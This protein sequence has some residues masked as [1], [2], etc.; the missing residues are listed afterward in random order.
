MKGE[1]GIAVHALVFLNHKGARQSS[2]TIADNVCTNA[3]RVRKVMAMLVNAGLAA[4]KEGADG[5]YTLARGAAEIDLA[6]VL[7]AVG[8]RLIEPAWHSGSADMDCLIA[9]GMAGVMDNI[10][11]ELNGLCRESLRGITVADIDETIFGG[12]KGHE[13][14]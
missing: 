8:V 1:F 4:K 7:D 3:S 6:A 10:Y 2:E 9:S 5:G 11:G 12:G 13:K 14:V